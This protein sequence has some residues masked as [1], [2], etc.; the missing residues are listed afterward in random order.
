MSSEAVGLQAR[1]KALRKKAVYT[2]CCGHNLN[3]VIVSAF[4]FP[5]TKNVLEKV[6]EVGRMF[7]K[8]SKKMKLLE[9]VVKQNPRYSSQIV[10]FNV[11]LTRW[12]E[13]LDEYNHFL[14]T[15][16]YIKE[17]LEE[18]FEK[19]L[20]MPDWDNE[21]RRRVVNFLARISNFEFCVVFTTIVKSTFYFQSPFSCT[22]E[23]KI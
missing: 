3:L 23:N 1:I 9:E 8:D 21:S 4:K 19:Y 12:V 16:P 17:A 2:H 11:C 6:Q 22:I 13:N 14:L 5:V 20:N 18:V 7:I 10:I 15:Y